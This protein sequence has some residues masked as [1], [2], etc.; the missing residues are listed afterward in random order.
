VG[1]IYDIHNHLGSENG[2]KAISIKDET[3]WERKRCLTPNTGFP[4][5]PELFLV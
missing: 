2:G 4:A 5:L 1:R 3:C